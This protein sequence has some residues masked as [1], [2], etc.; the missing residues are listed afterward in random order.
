MEDF[1][2][3]R[4]I[5]D[6]LTGLLEKQSFYDCAQDLL[7]NADLDHR[8]SF[9]FFDLE[10]FK[11]FNANYGYEK[12]DELLAIIGKIIKDSF[13][14][15]L[16]SR[17][18]GDHF[19]VFTD[20]SN[21]IPN[22]KIIRD[23]IR[24]VQKNV[25]IELK[26]GIYNCDGS[27]KD[28][29][30]CCD[31]A[32]I[33]CISIKKKYDA[34]YKIYDDELGGSLQK[35]QDILDG[36][37][38]ALELKYIQVYYQPIIR[39]FT[40]KICGWEALVR[41]VDPLNG[42]IYPCEFIP[43]L[44]EYRLIPKIDAY[45]MEEVFSKYNDQM[46][47]KRETVP[48]SINLSRIDFEVMDLVAFID[49]KMTKYN[50]PKDMFHFEITESALMENP[51][52]ILEQITRLRENGYKVWMDDFGSGYSSLNLLKNYQFDLVKIDM[53]FLSNFENT[54]N[55][56][57]ILRHIVS[58]IKNLNMHTLVE[59]VETEEQYEFLRS[60]GCEMIQ[61]YL[62]GRPLPYL[63]GLRKILKDGRT[64]ERASE[65]F[66]YDKLGEID[67]LKQNPLQNTS[68]QPL[69]NPLPL[70]IGIVTDG[71]WKFVYTNAG[72]RE[73]VASFG[74][75]TIE[76]VEN[77]LSTEG[78]RG[79]PQNSLFSEICAHSKEK[80]RS[81]GMDFI[82]GGKI[83]NMR[84]RHII[85]DKREKKD[86][87]LISVR[88]LSRVLTTNNDAK[89]SAIS[90]NIFSH[91]ECVDLYGI[92]ED[93]FENIYL[94]DSR[95]HIDF[96]NKGARQVLQEISERLVHPED[97]ER[98]LTYMNLSTVEERIERERGESMLE[99]YRILDVNGEY[100]WK[101]IT[102]SIMHLE[103]FD[104][105]LGYIREAS[106]EMVRF[107]EEIIENWRENGG[108]K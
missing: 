70:A 2:E 99:F 26:A 19:V 39:A 6:E 41:W 77:T 88:S 14:G 17:F 83:I 47:K 57:I 102:L 3:L 1:K 64:V 34:E 100:R 43:V 61:G 95:L 13:K 33:A 107:M 87:Y 94:H 59:G 30:R 106:S 65:R 46:M 105:V 93:Y 98:F 15:Q 9:V 58:M 52:F 67:V 48:V 82:Q 60:I 76:E 51:Q 25:N 18:S 79:W 7:D 81:E 92:Q 90:N 10:N 36:L 11:I 54:D 21:I 104:A 50:C 56:K 37:D 35:K 75:K 84:V 20:S 74:Y 66:F 49:E 23:K 63:E 89:I 71:K 78:N 73:L 42:I 4:L 40:G 28:V 27:D 91:Y 55:G 101:G 31:R 38:E 108:K 53:D 62:I 80:G 68:N 44:E 72:V 103:N 32:R 8:Y 69:E 5:I 24:L 96:K 12:G 45:V 85:E 16:I 97:K 22:I 86:A 29:I